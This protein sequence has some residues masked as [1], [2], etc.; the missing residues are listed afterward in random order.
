MKE[1]ELA[2]DVVKYL[3]NYDLYFE[4]LDMDIVAKSG[5]I[6]TSVEVKT[7]LNFKVIEQ[8]KRNK[9]YCHY[10]YIAIPYAKNRM[11]AYSICDNLGIGVLE[12]EYSKFNNKAYIRETVR[13]KVNRVVISKFIKSHLTPEKKEN[14]PGASGSDGTTITAFKMT[15][16]RME[17][18]IERHPGCTFKEL[19]DNIDHHYYS[20]TSARGSTYQWINK[21]VIKSIYVSNGKLYLNDKKTLT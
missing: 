15:L 10:S 2:K 8:A 5:N 19:F 13:P 3:E 17:E 1:V 6:L 21:G 4:V 7:N 9:S 14:V 11:F 18:Y 16:D 20:F 12:I